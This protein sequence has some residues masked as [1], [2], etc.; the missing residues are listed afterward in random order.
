MHT[1]ATVKPDAM[2]EAAVTTVLGMAA[3]RPSG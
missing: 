3:A 2:L 1:V